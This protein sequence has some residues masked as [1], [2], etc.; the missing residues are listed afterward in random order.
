MLSFEQD[1][2]EGT[3]PAPSGEETTPVNHV[4]DLP[5]DPVAVQE[6]PTSAAAR[7]LELAALTAD[8]LVTDAEAE[9]ESLVTRAQATAEEIV[10]TSRDEADRAAAELARRREEQAADLDRERATTLSGLADE[11]ANLE[12]QIATLRQLASEHR[13]QMRHHLPEQLTLLDN[14]QES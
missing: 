7:M 6:A 1:L 3:T 9:A 10:G 11:K 5:A 14:L 13:D 12:S 2:G 4:A 8:R